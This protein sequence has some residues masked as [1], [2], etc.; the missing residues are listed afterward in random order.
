MKRRHSFHRLYY[1][2]V[3]HT[4]DRQ[5]LITTEEEGQRLRGYM[6][7]KAK[8]LDVYIEEAGHW[9]DHVHLLFRCGTTRAL[10]DVYG[11]LKGFS[12]TAWRKHLPDRP[13]KWGDGV[14]ITTVDPDNKTALRDYIKFQWE[15][16]ERRAE[17]PKWEHSEDTPS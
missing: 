13:F 7:A 17:I 4:K 14:Y 2:V 11:Q 15:R 1:H 12:A 16:H 10:S 8:D 5:H 3:M 6:A 9:R